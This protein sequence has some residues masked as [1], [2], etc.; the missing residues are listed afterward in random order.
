MWVASRKWSKF[1]H[2]VQDIMQ[3]RVSEIFFKWTMEATV[4]KKMDV[5]AA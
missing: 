1:L 2:S 3:G 5:D 4:S